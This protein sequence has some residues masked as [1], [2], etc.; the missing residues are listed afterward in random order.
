MVSSKVSSFHL[1]VGYVPSSFY[2]E[3]EVNKIK[4]VYQDSSDSINDKIILS[5]SFPLSESLEKSL[6]LHQ[7][8]G[9]NLIDM[10]CA[11]LKSTTSL[12]KIKYFPFLYLSDVW[13]LN[14]GEHKYLPSPFK[15]KKIISSILEDIIKII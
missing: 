3:S 14:R 2:T 5:T 4:K 15:S 12:N 9:I 8:Y 11:F 6:T 10:E 13:D 1:E 7:D